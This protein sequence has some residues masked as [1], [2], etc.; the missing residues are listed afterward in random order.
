MSRVLGIVAEYNP[1][2]NGHAYHIR[3][4]KRRTG[5]SGVVCVLS[6]NFVQRGNTSIVNKWTKAEMA[7]RSGA[8]LVLEL[9]V[10]YAV[11]S[12]E[13]YAYGAMRL[14]DSLRI[15][16]TVSFGMETNDIGVVED[17][18]TVLHKEPKEFRHILQHELEKGISFPQA[19]EN[20]LLMYL[21]DIK[22]YANVL[23]GS[24]NILAIEYIKALKKL[25]SPMHVIGVKRE[26]VQYHQEEI[27]E[28]FASATA[29]RKLLVKEEYDALKGVM[30]KVIFYFLMEQVKRGKWVSDL[31]VFE[32]AILC[33]LRKMTVQE[34][35]QLPDVAEGLEYAIKE[36]AGMVNNLPDFLSMVKS[37]RYTQTR[38]QRILVYA[39]L[40]ITKKQ[41]QTMT[42]AEP[43][44]RVLGFTPV[45]K[46]ML[47]DMTRANPKLPLI[48][49]VKRFEETNK[50]KNLQEML[51][52][53]KLAT[54]IYTLGQEGESC[55]N[56]DYTHKMMIIK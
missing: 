7:L 25:K 6:G 41:V 14:L 27:V 13:R 50:N 17:I 8:D 22:R 52:L 23:R 30:P 55:A 56:L 4:S 28:Q 48:T 44:A 54:D 3:E 9:P 18:A 49:S 11:G 10:V 37:K 35:A 15:V 16:D 32:K 53:D 19:R 46:Q 20:A 39:L 5:A 36:A 24:N 40:G 1:F 43:Y 29:V 47:A 51:D 45:G 33:N 12:A 26:K 2:H 38:L 31:C 42:K 21:N 34:I